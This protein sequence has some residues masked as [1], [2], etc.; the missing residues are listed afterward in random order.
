MKT[1]THLAYYLSLII[2]L[3][4][5]GISISFASPNR[6]LQLQLITLTAFFYFLW[7]ILHHS[8]NHDLV[9]KT[10]IEYAL[11]AILGIAISLFMLKGG[12]GI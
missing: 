2:I 1:K 9:F 6:F 8:V 5:G 4:L 7:G 10:V 3:A 11:I 12:L